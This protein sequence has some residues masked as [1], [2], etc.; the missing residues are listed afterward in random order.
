MRTA[1]PTVAN[2]LLRPE[3]TLGAFMIACLVYKIKIMQPAAVGSLLLAILKHDSGIFGAVLGCYALSV[4]LSKQVA[5]HGAYVCIRVVSILLAV[6]GLLIVLTY[7]ADVFVYHFFSTRLYIGDLIT[8]ASEPEAGWTLLSTGAKVLLRI[9][10]WKM[11]ALALG[12]GLLIRASWLLL[13]RP[14]HLPGRACIAVFCGAASMLLLSSVAMPQ[15]AYS[16]GDKPLYENF[17]ERNLDYVDT[18]EFSRAYR[19]ELLATQLPESCRAGEGKRVNVMLVIVESLSAYHSR[20]FS[21]IEDWTPR[22]DE[23]ARGETALTNFYANGWTTIGGLIALLS[24]KLPIPPERNAFNEWGS[25]RFSDFEDNHESIARF[26]DAIGYDT[27][28]I[29]GGDLSF[30]GQADWLRR[31]GFR[32]IIG[33]EDVRLA[34]E[35]VRGPFN[36]VTDGALYAVALDEVARRAGGGPY[37]MVVQTF[38]SHRPFRSPDGAAADSEET[39]I[40][41]ADEQIEVLHTR[42]AELGFLENGVLILTGDHRAMERFR[43]A[44]FTRFGQSAPAR[45]PAVV[46]T[47]AIRLPN[48]ISQDFQQ[49]DVPSSIR[50][51]VGSDY[52]THPLEGTFLGVRSAP[53]MCVIHARGDDRDLVYVKCGAQEGVVSI[54]GDSTSFVAGRVEPAGTVLYAVNRARARELP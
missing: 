1:C 35:A 18:G 51:L 47:R 31:M 39:V 44:E 34:R 3:A 49:R 46:A 54:D 2:F 5:A 20:Y 53:P 8:H 38:W 13:L 36:S 37:L 15:Y 7:A 23:I 41:H 14:R 21:G 11:V 25:P 9:D 28:F 40:R 26:L 50:A 24:G 10:A 30:L 32:R 33:L 45:I 12:A 52:C 27:V 6:V 29:G 48:V 17:V 16:H 22:L 19:E 43:K 42:L 4:L